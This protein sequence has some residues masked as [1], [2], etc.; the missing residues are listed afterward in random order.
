M[1]VLS[2]KEISEK[3]N[4]FGVCGLCMVQSYNKLPTKNGGS[5]VGGTLSTGEGTI[6]FKSWGNTSAY[7]AF[8]ENDLS[9][10]VVDVEAEVNEYNG[11]KS[12]IVGSIIDIYDGKSLARLGLKTEDFMCSRYNVKE[13]W[14]AFLELVKKKVSASAYDAFLA[15]LEGKED[16]FKSEFASTAHHDNCRGGL[17]AHSFK[18]VS[19]ASIVRL[20]PELEKRVGA[21]LLYL[22][23]ALHD[24]GKIMEYE[25]GAVTYLGKTV[26]HTVYGVVMLEGKRDEIVRLMG[27]DFY[28]DLLSVVSCHHGEYGE[29][30]RTVASYIIHKLDLIESMFTS[31][32]EVIG[33]SDGD[34]VAFDGFKLK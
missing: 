29:R 14:N 16:R 24:I 18:T 4:R 17:L 11:V 9:G 12:V 34:V 2:L 23:C 26:S 25:N 1:K 28:L 22:G 20:Y 21:D 8:V 13:Y 7:N 31:L 15:I 10:K 30:P 19:M 32:Q 5:Y 3:P 6:E 33:S 27:E